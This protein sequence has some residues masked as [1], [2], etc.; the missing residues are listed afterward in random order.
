MPRD[1][2]DRK[3]WVNARGAASVWTGTSEDLHIKVTADYSNQLVDKEEQENYG[4]I[5][6]DPIEAKKK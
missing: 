6:K 2:L 3:D 1:E 4:Q 5:N